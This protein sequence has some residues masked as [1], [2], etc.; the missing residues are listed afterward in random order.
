MEGFIGVATIVLILAYIGFAIWFICKR[1]TVGGSIGASAVF[2]CG[3]LVVIPAAEAIAT[4]VCWA[5]VIAL[6]L[7]IIGAIFGG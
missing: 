5:I 2:L 3:G 4:F 7:A 6:V 1:Q